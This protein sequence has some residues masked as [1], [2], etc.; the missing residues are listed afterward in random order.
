MRHRG[1]NNGR[2]ICTYDDFAEYGIRRR[3]ISR[4]LRNLRKVGL[5]EVTQRGRRDALR[6]PHHYR[7][8]YLVSHDEAGNI[9]PPA[10][11]W[12]KYRQKT[13]QN[14]HSAQKSRGENAPGTRDE[15][16]PG[17]GGEN[18]PT[19]PEI[20]GGE[21]DLTFYNLSISSPGG[22]CLEAE[23]EAE[24]VPFGIGHNAGPSLNSPIPLKGRKQKRLYLPPAKRP[25]KRAEAT[26]LAA[27]Y[28]IEQ[29]GL[30]RLHNPNAVAQVTARLRLRE[31]LTERV[32]NGLCDFSPCLEKLPGAGND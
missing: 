30:R 12:K 14:G 13:K 5:L 16:D 10:D 20:T 15:N 1:T 6:N 31:R 7:L 17:T 25:D 3:S 19:A 11:E 32:T 8:P 26:Y 24:A 22:G 28:Q 27:W 18:A 21:N 29:Q 9:I 4:G 2:I 23:A